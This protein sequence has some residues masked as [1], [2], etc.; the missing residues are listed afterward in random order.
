VRAAA[1]WDTP[2]A[3]AAVKRVLLPLILFGIAFGYNEAMQVVSL[4]AVA[5]PVRAGLG[6]PPEELFPLPSLG[7][8]GPLRAL[9]VEEQWREAA[10][11]AMLAGV[12]W[13]V[14]RDFRMWLAALSFV[15]GVW[16]LA[17]YGWLRVL[18]GWPRT[19]LD[20]DV[21]FLLPVPWAAPVLAPV[22]SAGSLV[23]GGA[24]ALL[25]PPPRVS[26]LAWG[27]L[28]ACAVLMTVSFAWDWRDWIAGGMPHGFPWALF[29]GAEI[30]GVA[31]YLVTRRAAR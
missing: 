7:R 13:A 4:R 28:A 12:A 29:G 14:T 8:I 26:K 30:L 9:V 5:A 10:T 31:G 24:V 21:L 25:D 11:I 15:F 18:L 17:Y 27:L 19:L 6:L 22:I 20:W 1:E 23:W 2:A 16:D 3:R